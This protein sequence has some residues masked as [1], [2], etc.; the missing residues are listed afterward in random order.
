[1]SFAS[2]KQALSSAP[3]SNA[4]CLIVSLAFES[5]GSWSIIRVPDPRA[6]FA[7]A[8]SHLYPP[9]QFPASIHPSAVVAEDAIIDPR[10]HIGAHVTV[11]AS[12]TIASGCVISGGCIIGDYVT[13][14]KDTF[15]HPNVTVYER[16]H[17]GA[18]VIIHAGTVIG[19]DGF[20]FTLVEGHYRKFPQVG[21]VV[22]HDNVEIGAGC[23]ID[24]AA[25]GT[26]RIGFGTKIDNLVHIGH[27]CQ[28]GED[29]VVAAQTGF[30]GSVTVGDFAVIGGQVG[31]GEKAHIEARAIIG[32][33][34]GILTAATVRAGEPVWGIPARPLR[35][36]LKA[37]AN[38]NKLPELK[39]IIRH[40]GQRILTLERLL[41]ED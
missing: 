34:A 28:I 36:H 19:A 30:S 8:L 31:I 12:T 14:G 9:K 41:K 38:L 7:R 3:S 2:G 4:G 39:E 20:G 26:T 16:V 23:C 24:R 5:S 21:T 33:K 40:L 11:G 10:C 25:L 37:L 1:L 13:L 29:I 32:G 17:I 18:R 35:K 22:I 15:L 6:A 27:N